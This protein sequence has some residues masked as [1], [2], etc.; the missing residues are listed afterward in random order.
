KPH[1]GSM[2]R[3]SSTGRLGAAL[4]ALALAAAPLVARSEGSAAGADPNATTSSGTC[5]D[6][7][8]AERERE[9]DAKLAELGRRLSAEPKPAQGDGV[10]VRTGWN[11][12]SSTPAESA[13]PR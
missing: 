10:L 9:R 2:D 7:H 13:Q 1:G 6:D 3:R 11:Y 4:A 8:K 5:Q 12:G